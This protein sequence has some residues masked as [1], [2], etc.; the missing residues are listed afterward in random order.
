MTPAITTGRKSVGDTM[1]ATT[2]DDRTQHEAVHNL[3]DSR[4]NATKSLV[5]STEDKFH[6]AAEAHNAEPDD[7]EK[8][9]AMREA[10]IRLSATR[11]VVQAIE[12]YWS[13]DQLMPAIDNV[14]R[15][16]LVNEA[17]Q[18]DV[19]TEACG[20]C[21]HYRCICGQGAETVQ[22]SSKLVIDDTGDQP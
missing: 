17:T 1:N 15:R 19:P 4:W 20:D 12:P 21:G 9:W 6:E 7:A 8:A 3:I 18:L 2:R 10:Y 14:S 22:I 11:A 16:A 13:P 5:K